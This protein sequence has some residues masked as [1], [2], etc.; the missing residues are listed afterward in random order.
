MNKGK[1]D[2][3]Q[4]SIAAEKSWELLNVCMICGSENWRP[5]LAARANCILCK[6]DDCS[7]I[8]LNPRPRKTLRTDSGF[9]S[10]HARAV[11]LPGLVKSGFLSETFVP[12]LDRLYIRYKKLVDMVVDLS[13][14]A[15]VID[16]GCGIGLSMLALSSRGIKTIGYDV[17]ETFLA[18]ATETFGLD[19]RMVD[20]F[21]PNLTDRHR[22]ITLNA[23]LEHINQPVE[24]L[25][26]IRENVLTPDGAL[27]LTLPNIL[28]YQYLQSGVE[29]ATI[30]GGH[31]WYPTENST[32]RVAAMAGF[33][34]ETVHAPPPV[35][36]N[37]D[38]YVFFLRDVMGYEGNISAGLG[39]VLRASS[40]SSPSTGREGKG[41]EGPQGC[42]KV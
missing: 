39:M 22:I 28:S 13:P 33:T 4:I 10:T 25:R 3:L 8:F 5:A 7:S 32:T 26:A 24:F 19:V 6:C 21:D 2:K 40:R 38:P 15:P 23:V 17:D 35:R 1:P 27:V 20:V 9:N 16:V 18:V 37:N 14:T 42:L 36:H 31:V 34:V 41:R 11:Y 30:S 12:H 29:W